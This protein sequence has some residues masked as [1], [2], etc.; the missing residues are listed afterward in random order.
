[1]TPDLL[2]QNGRCMLV[3]RMQDVDIAIDGGRI[4]AIVEPGQLSGARDVIDAAGLIVLPGAIDAHVHVRDPGQTHK[5]DYAHATRAAAVA[6]VTTIISQP[7][8]NP[9]TTDGIGLAALVEATRE[10]RVDHAF[11]AGIEVANPDNEGARDVVTGGAVAFEALGDS[12]ALDGQG[13]LGLFGAVAPLGVP[14]ALFATD[15]GV[16]RHNIA[17]ARARTSSATN[18]RDFAKAVSGE[19]EAIGFHRAAGLSR[20]CGTPLIVRQVTTDAGLEAIRQEK[21][22]AGNVPLW[23]EVNVHHLFLNDDDLD[24]VGPYAQMLPPPRLESELPALWDSLCDGTIDFISTDHAPHTREEKE[25]GRSDLWTVPTGIPGLDSF[26]CLLL[27]AVF[28]GRLSLSRMVELVSENPARIHRLAPAKGRI[29]V[30][31]DADLMLVDSK[32]TWTIEENRIFSRCGWSAFEG[33]SGRGVPV[34]TMVRGQVVARGGQPLDGL[35]G[36][37]IRP[38]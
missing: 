12:G 30:G 5:E 25:A 34:L 28:S 36:R 26:M 33:R 13:W 2:V 10:S 19:A 24:R 14:L 16:M 9:P 22:R 27:D 6:G 35:V 15:R 20:V 23:A 1:M 38:Q 3:G 4:I 29:A 37:L 8:T 31:A 32:A 18:W 17:S 11:C 21:D 7:N